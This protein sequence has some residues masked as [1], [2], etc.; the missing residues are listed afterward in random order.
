MFRGEKPGETR[1]APEW[2]LERTARHAIDFWLSTEDL[3]RPDNRV[4][5]AD[6][7]NVRLAYTSSNDVPKQQLYD[8]LKSILGKLDMNPH[9]L[10]H[11]FAYMKNEIPVAG[12]AHQAGTARFGVDPATLGAQHR[13]PRA[14]GRQS[15]RRRHELLPEHRRR[16]SGADGHGERAPR[17]GSPARSAA[18]MPVHEP[19]P[20]S[21]EQFELV[22]ADQKAVVVEVGGGLRTYSA[23][24]RDILDGYALDVPCTSGRG[25]VLAPWPNRLEDGRYE[26]DGR[27]YQLPLNEPERRN[28]IH[29]LVRW[30]AWAV[31]EREHAPRRD[32]AH[33]PSSARLSLLARAEHRILAVRAGT[34]RAD[35]GDEHRSRSLPVR[36]R[37]PSLPDDR[38]RDRR[39]RALA[40]ARA[41]GTCSPTSAICPIGR[42]VR[43]RHR[44]R[45]SRS[46]AGGLDGTRRLLHRPRTRRRRTSRASS[47]AIRTAPPRS[48]SGSTRPIPT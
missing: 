40:R 44:L 1:L 9:H 22:H 28:A 15:L 20:P 4:T 24:G 3:P 2:T 39:P 37:R 17:G 27:R 16:E 36:D 48:P 46:E 19:T 18:L 25:Q 5:L 14:R 33:G 13:L 41:R 45:L 7:G 23:G 43:R 38:D 6:D 35:D 29:G 21:G 34:A 8:K 26:F 42:A 32:E 47:S 10:I 11:R 31:A 30:A 12:C